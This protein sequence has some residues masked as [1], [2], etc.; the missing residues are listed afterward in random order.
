MNYR[1]TKSYQDIFGQTQVRKGPK[2][3]WVYA[4]SNKAMPGIVKIGFTTKAP[5]ERANMLG[6]EGMPHPY[7]VEYAALVDYPQSVEEHVHE[8]LAE[9]KERKE[10]FRCGTEKAVAAI[11][12]ESD[13]IYEEVDSESIEQAKRAEADKKRKERGKVRMENMLRAREFRKNAEIRREKRV[14][15]EEYRWERV[16]VEKTRQ[17]VSGVE[18]LFRSIGNL[19]LLS[20]PS[21][22]EKELH[23][24]ERSSESSGLFMVLLFA[25]VVFVAGGVYGIGFPMLLDAIGKE[26]FKVLMVVAIVV[27]I[28]VNLRKTASDKKSDAECVKNM[29]HVANE[30][31]A[32]KLSVINYVYEFEYLSKEKFDKL[33]VVTRRKVLLDIQLM[34][35][36]GHLTELGTLPYGFKSVD[37]IE[38]ALASLGVVAFPAS[39]IN[40]NDQWETEVRAENEILLRNKVREH[41]KQ[42][43]IIDGAL[44]KTDSGDVVGFLKGVIKYAEIYPRIQFRNG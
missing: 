32:I 10:W 43:M 13:N 30:I 17:I 23:K 34:I 16:R 22:A 25:L 28:I 9:Y 5:E 29:S 20:P 18:N 15:A 2:M 41:L 27:A 33:D 31:L 6:R 19:K 35:S 36:A 12:V 7:I 42:K 14:K 37:E 11:Q 8:Q 44:T 4:I 24:T 1:K 39:S 26:N 21:A 40:T 38:R 3:G